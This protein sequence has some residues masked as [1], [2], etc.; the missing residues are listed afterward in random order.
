MVAYVP[1]IV[2][3]TGSDI[4]LRLSVNH[5][6]CTFQAQELPRLAFVAAA[7]NVMLKLELRGVPLPETPELHT[8][9]GVK[10][11]ETPEGVFLSGTELRKALAKKYTAGVS[12]E[13]DDV[14]RGLATLQNILPDSEISF[15]GPNEVEGMVK[16]AIE[17][18]TSET[19][20]IDDHHPGQVLRGQE[21][22]SAVRVRCEL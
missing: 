8:L 2:T 6:K 10:K 3:G 11:T 18:V 9:P 12:P 5:E 20:V 21:A 19:V 1:I 7:R 14:R 22:S 16:T 13:P 15:I 17:V 4:N